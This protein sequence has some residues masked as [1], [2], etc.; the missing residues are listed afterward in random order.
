MYMYKLC[1]D[2]LYNKCNSTKK[3]SSFRFC[4]QTTR[5]DKEV[6]TVICREYYVYLVFLDL[7][8]LD[9]LVELQLLPLHD[10]PVTTSTLAMQVV[11][12]HKLRNG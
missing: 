6:Y 2:T 5:H 7:S 4:A 10:V 9:P 1:R 12:T 8:F 11:K 3:M